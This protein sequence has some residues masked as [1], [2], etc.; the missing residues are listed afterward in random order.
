M[1][2]IV[3]VIGSVSVTVTVCTVTPF[4]VSLAYMVTDAATEVHI[5]HHEKF[6]VKTEF[7][8]RRNLILIIFLLKD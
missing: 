8:V 6:A 7:F 2:S 1:E 5:S 4:P 3:K